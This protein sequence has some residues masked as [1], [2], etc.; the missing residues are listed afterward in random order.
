MTKRDTI[1]FHVTLGAGTK[2][3]L[4]REAQ[5]LGI[6]LSSLIAYILGTHVRNMERVYQHLPGK[7][8]DALIQVMNV[9][10]EIP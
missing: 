5:G 4:E 8:Q 2:Q 10:D 9:P 1:R 3:A 7:I 6:S